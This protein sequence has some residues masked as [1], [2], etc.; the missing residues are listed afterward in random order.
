MSPVYVFV[1]G[2]RAQL[3]KM[4]PVMRAAADEGHPLRLVLTGQHLDSMVELACDLQVAEFFPTAELQTERATVTG[5]LTWFPR[6]F[7]ECRRKLKAAASGVRCVVLVHGDTA[8]TLLGALAARS[9]RL[10][11]AHI[12]SGLSSGKLLDPFPEELCRRL[13]FRLTTFAFCPNDPALQR[14]KK[15]PRVLAFDTQGNTIADALSLALIAPAEAGEPNAEVVVSIHRFENIRRHERLAQIVDEIIRIAESQTVAF[16]L[17]P[18]TVSKLLKFS[19]YQRMDL[20][21]GIRLMNRMS[22]SRFI[23]LVSSAS[24]VITDGGSNQEE[25]ALMGMPTL[26]LRDRSERSDGLGQ[27]AVL[28]PDLG[29]RVSD[30][31]LDGRSAELRRPPSYSVQRSVSTGIVQQINYHLPDGDASSATTR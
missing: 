26:L 29:M 6:A 8:S 20:H 2:T 4:A 1:I 25:F 28:E 31:V 3:V 22:Y 13:V 16:V 21:P 5:L 10:T 14:M 18:S 19:L 7:L 17:H 30:Y 9:L 11:V 24:V 15:Y 27:N 12:E 23:R